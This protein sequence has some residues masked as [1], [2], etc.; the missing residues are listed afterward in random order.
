MSSP[1]GEHT[2]VSARWQKLG[3]RPTC[4]ALRRA[5]V[6]GS[7]V[8]ALYVIIGTRT[9][10][11]W[12]YGLFW[13]DRDRVS[14]AREGLRWLI[15][16]AF[17]LA[18][19]IVSALIVVIVVGRLQKRRLFKVIDS[20]PWVILVCVWLAVAVD[21]LVLRHTQA[22]KYILG[23]T[24]EQALQDLREHA[25]P[26]EFVTPIYFHWVDGNRVES[27]Y[28]QLEPELAVKEREITGKTTLKGGATAG[29]GET[30]IGVEMNS[31]NG[32]KSTYTPAKLLADRK[33]VDVMRYVR[34]T[35]PENYFDRA[36]KWQ[37]RMIYQ[38]AYKQAQ[39]RIDYSTLQP[40]QPLG[41]KEGQHRTLTAPEKQALSELKS[42]RG[43]LFIEGDFDQTVA[44]DKV[45]LEQKFMDRPFKCWFRA[46][47][48]TSA[49]GS[50]PMTR[51]L[52]LTVFGDVTR[53]LRD[54]GY[55]D[56]VAIAV[57]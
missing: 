36:D 14:Y 13:D 11:S 21:A 10:R 48:P 51:P 40:I 3:V 6:L 35:W 54:D 19:G 33:C 29:V 18:L 28:N 31:E 43:Y 5:L 44:G 42:L 57:Y 2:P 41:D 30:K 12:W 22:D 24:S 50:L 9:D 4:I 20:A 52:H 49:A 37:T 45:L 17:W 55:V 23:M 56:V 26:P 7:I 38:R 25:T 32:A 8:V 39:G 34:D 46:V 27:L 47:L 15:D 16:D 1:A 53:P